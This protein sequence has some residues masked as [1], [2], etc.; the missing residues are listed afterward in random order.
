MGKKIEFEN[1]YIEYPDE[2]ILDEEEKIEEVNDKPKA[3]KLS[4]EE[5]QKRLEETQSLHL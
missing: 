5:L 1:V 2:L 4:L 3:E